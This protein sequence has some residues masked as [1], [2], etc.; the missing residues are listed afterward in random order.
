MLNRSLAFVAKKIKVHASKVYLLFEAIK[1]NCYTNSV[2]FVWQ[3]PYWSSTH[4][5]AT[6]N[7]TDLQ[8]D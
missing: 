8:A 5:Q 4:L 3:G 1:H 7:E 6:Q 2:I